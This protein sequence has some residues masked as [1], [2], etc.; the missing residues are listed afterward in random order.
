MPGANNRVAAGVELGG[1]KLQ[2]VVLRDGE[3]AGSSPVRTPGP[4]VRGM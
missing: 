2:T 4:A 1:T 3:V